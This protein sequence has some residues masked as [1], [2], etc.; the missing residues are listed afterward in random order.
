LSKGLRQN[1]SAWT[2]VYVAVARV[3]SISS[4]LLF[5]Y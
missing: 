4:K 3:M 5:N 1:H 2:L